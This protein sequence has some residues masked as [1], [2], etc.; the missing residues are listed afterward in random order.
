MKKLIL[1]FLMIA[2]ALCARTWTLKS[3]TKVDGEL[4]SNDGTHIIIKRTSGKKGKIKISSLTAADQQYL[5]SKKQPTAKATVLTTIQGKWIIDGNAMIAMME[6]QSGVK[7]SATERKMMLTGFE[8]TTYTFANGKILAD[9]EIA[10][11]S[12]TYTV[13]SQNASRADIT[14]KA[15]N[16]E[17]A[18]AHLLL[19]NKKLTFIIAN[20]I[21]A[22]LTR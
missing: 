9:F 21:E 14:V 17:S 22:V 7:Y 3:G 4:L 12:W 19:V 20:R 16:G 6:K 18:R 8:G 13:N 2:T 11:K 10:K 15:E 5:N 1:I